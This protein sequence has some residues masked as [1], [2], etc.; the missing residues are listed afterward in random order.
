MWSSKV[1]HKYKFLNVSEKI[2]HDAVVYNLSPRISSSDTPVI[3]CSSEYWAIPYAG[4]GGPVFLSKI[5]ACGKIDP[6]TAHLACLNG[7]K[8]ECLSIAFSPFAP[9]VLATGGDDAAVVLWDA[10]REEIGRSSVR[11][12]THATSVRDLV[13]HP[14]A[15]GILLSCGADGHLVLWDLERSAE[16]LEFGG[17]G[18]ISLE[19]S[20]DGRLVVAS[21]RD[22]TLRAVD[23]RCAEVAWACVP[24]EGSRSFRAT[25][26]G[27]NLV[28]S[29]GPSGNVGR[30][31]ALVDPRFL[32][33]GGGGVAARKQVDTQT[34]VLLPHY[35][36]ETGVLWV[37]GRGDATARHYEVTAGDL[38]PGLEWRTASGRPHA[39]VAALPSRCLDVGNLEIARFLRLTTTTVDTV[40]Y[41][42]AR[43]PDLKSYFNDDI[44]PLRGA[45]APDPALHAPDWLDG[46]DELP[47]LVTLR[48]DGAPL[49]S[50]RKVESKV[51]NT[52]VV[53]RRLEHE[54]HQRA[55]DH[56]QYER[57]TALAN[58][59]EKYQPNNSMGSRPGVDA[60]PVDGDDVADDE[61]DD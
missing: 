53:N 31:I 17:A 8:A 49:L 30:E 50:E 57:L 7:H 21:G 27:E 26:A 33:G 48:P 4:G 32:G 54:K 13:F 19:F 29:A 46:R 41:S 38:V 15:S 22:R 25:W 39:G 43:T 6:A 61:W 35:S 58:Q 3:A 52:A 36:E 18:G 28:A 51:L 60:A 24:H 10:N 5:D 9:H 59:F 11:L 14:T 55:Y 23:M 20:Y 47:K 45:R 12:G 1:A 37:W 16:A 2:N 34:G 42:V 40:S 44:Y 56:A